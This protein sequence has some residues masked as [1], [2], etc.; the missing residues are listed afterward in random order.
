MRVLQGSPPLRIQRQIESQYIDP[1]F[2]QHAEL[3]AF[4][5]FPDQHVHAFQ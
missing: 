1:G 2:T 4:S 3:A 5:V